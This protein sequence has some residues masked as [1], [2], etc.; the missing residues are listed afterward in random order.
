MQKVYLPTCFT[1]LNENYGLPDFLLLTRFVILVI[2][3]DYLKCC[4]RLT[5]GEGN[6]RRRTNTVPSR[7]L[8]FI[9]RWQ[10]PDGSRLTSG[11][12][13]G[14]DAIVLF[15]ITRTGKKK[16]VNTVSI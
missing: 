3:P 5:P 4:L 9:Y 13:G 2:R 6:T 8:K 16:Y 12:L 11:F 15:L 1:K 14:T 7:D 10:Q